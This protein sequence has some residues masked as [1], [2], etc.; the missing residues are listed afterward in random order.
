MS[1]ICGSTKCRSKGSWLSR[2]RKKKPGKS[3]HRL[4]QSR[5][6]N[7]A[8]IKELTANLLIKKEEE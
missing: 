5:V 7:L 3:Q 6:I 1:L 8:K 4:I 2:R